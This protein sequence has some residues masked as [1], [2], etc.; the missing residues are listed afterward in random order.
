VFNLVQMKIRAGSTS[1][2]NKLQM[3]ENWAKAVPLIEKAIMAIRA[4]EG[5][6]GDASAERELVRET[7]ARFDE[8][9][10]VDR[11]LPPKPMAAPMAAAPGL[12]VPGG[13]TPPQALA[14]EPVMEPAGM[15][16]GGRPMQVPV[17]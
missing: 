13:I 12:P 4:I 5:A 3:Q 14:P 15:A 16:V 10:D 11:F 17:Q 6:G 1:A 7:I 2:P 9:I 8:S